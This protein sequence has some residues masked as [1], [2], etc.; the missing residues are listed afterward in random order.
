MIGNNQNQKLQALITLK[1]KIVSVNALY[2]AR[3]VY[4]FG[5]PVPV[6]YKTKEGKDMEREIR[7]QM[8]SINI[9][10]HIDWI[11]NTKYFDLNIQFIFKKSISRRDTSNACKAV[12]DSWVNWLK[13]DV[14]IENYDDSK[15]ARVILSKS[16]IPNSEHEYI[17]I[18][19]TPSNFNVRFDKIDKPEQALIYFED[20]EFKETKEFK[21]AFK[22]HGLKYQL[23]NTD[24]KIKDYNTNILFIN[25]VDSAKIVDIVDFIFS[26]KDSGFTYLGFFSD[27]GTSVINKINALVGS[28]VKACIIEKPEDIL[29]IIPKNEE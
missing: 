25:D 19:L 1:T 7:E 20:P 29:S 10:E 13:E 22:E 21:K 17:L 5:K 15:H 2:A 3:L 6:L 23:Y 11:R 18:Q 8:R 24:K 9:D 14:G 12:E 16:I 28:N 4:K 26:H 27:P